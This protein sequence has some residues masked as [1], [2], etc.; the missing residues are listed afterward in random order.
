M[1]QLIEEH[2]KIAPKKV[3]FFH[4]KEEA[5]QRIEYWKNLYSNKKPELPKVEEKF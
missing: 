3:K 2:N 4:T 5:I 1:K